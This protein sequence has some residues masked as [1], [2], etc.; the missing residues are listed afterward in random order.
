MAEASGPTVK[1]PLGAHWSL[2]E[3]MA[4]EK[5]AFGFYFSAHPIDRYRHL[6]EAHGAKTYGALCGANIG[7][8]RV[9]GTMA[10]LVEDVRWRTSAKGRRYLLA[11][12]SDSSGQFV[13]SCFDDVAA[14]DLEEAARTGGCGLLSVELD[15][16]AG[17][18]APR[19]T[20]R[21]IRPFD[22]LSA[23]TRLVCEVELDD[24]SALFGLK[25]LVDPA[26][27]GRGE[28]RLIVKTKAGDADLRLGRD[29][30]LDAELSARIER[31]PGVVRVSLKAAELPRL[32]LVG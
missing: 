20:I 4:Q 31:M 17:E 13:A 26:R 1:P 29:F 22:G 5:E 25:A 23:N 15:K 7:E 3:R 18:E 8:E 10:G 2:A 27:G 9:P 28:L 11:T 12:C 21:G 14:K 19:V 16:R 32:A 24:P 6:A 30:R